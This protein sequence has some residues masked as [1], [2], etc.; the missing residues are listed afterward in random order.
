M[1]REPIGPFTLGQMSA[2]LDDPRYLREYEPGHA[3]Y[4]S[5]VTRMHDNN[6]VAGEWRD[7]EP[8]TLGRPLALGGTVGVGAENRPE[9]VA[10]IEEGLLAVNGSWGSQDG[11]R[12][13][14]SQ[15]L[16]STGRSPASSVSSASSPT[17]W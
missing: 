14:E 5:L 9:D 11:C 7:R 16:P 17:G 15:V 12:A 6:F 1:S 8:F 10:E 2:L 4:V 13:R 3:D